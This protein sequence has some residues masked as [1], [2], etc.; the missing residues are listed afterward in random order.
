MGS[1]RF[2][3]SASTIGSTRRTRFA[4]STP[5]SMRSISRA[6]GFDGVEPAATGR[7]SL[8]SLGSLEALHLRLSQPRAVEPPARARSRPQSGASLALGPSRA[9]PQDDR[10]LPQGQ[11]PRSTPGLRTLRANCA[12]RWDCSR[13]RASPSTAASSRRSTIATATSRRARWSAVAHSW[14]RASRAISLSSTRPT[15]RSRRRRW[16]PRRSISR[17]SWRGSTT[18]MKRLESYEKKM[19]A[20]PDQQISLTDPDSRSMATSGRGSGVVGYNVQ[21]AVETENHL[22]VT[23]EVTTSGSDR[24]Q[25]AR[26]GK[27]AKAVMRA[28]DSRCRC[29]SRILQQPRDPRLPGGRHHRDTAQADDIGRQVGRPLRQAGLH[30]RRDAGR[31]RCPAG[32]AL[33]YR[34]TERKRATRRCVA[35][36]R[37]R[38]AAAR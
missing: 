7:P 13:R 21:V 8:P 36:G 28:D 34:M 6:L 9:R 26:V 29:R 18:E 1:R 33:T 16:P 22:I 15:G 11:R 23:H 4:R 24:S 2:C 27:A 20:S 14:R 25:L 31:L 3:R 12:A 5:S 10:R 19:L 35:T 17:R 37:R 32:E 30:L 38:A